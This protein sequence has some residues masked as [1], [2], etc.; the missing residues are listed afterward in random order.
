LTLIQVTY[1]NLLLPGLS[2]K[3]S[4]WGSFV[5][6]AFIYFLSTVVLEASK[7]V[8]KGFTDKLI[9]GNYH[10]PKKEERIF[11]FIDL[12]ESTKLSKELSLEK[13]SFLIKEFFRDIEMAME[14]FDGEIYQYAGDQVIVTWHATKSNFNN[15][16][17]SF[18]SFHEHIKAKRSSYILRYGVAPRFMAAI[19]SG[20]V[21]TTW[22]GKMKRELVFQGETLNITARLIALGKNLSYP[23]LLT[24]EVAENLE[25]IMRERVVE[26][27]TYSLKDVSNPMTI[28]F[29]RPEVP[30]EKIEKIHDKAKAFSINDQVKTRLGI[31][32]PILSATKDWQGDS[33]SVTE[34]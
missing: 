30:S 4:I 14:K 24:K 26:A 7:L 13:Y 9:L 8:G 18:V 3:A 16:A 31:A 2:D 6:Y 10:W 19:H 17:L 25:G 12:K 28:Y 23:I 21:I 5:F 33:L 20:I 11:L 34:S 15:A 1:F 27:G 29:L 32:T 22:V